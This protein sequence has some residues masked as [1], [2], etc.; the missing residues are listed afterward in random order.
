MALKEDST[1][2]AWGKNEYGQTTG[3]PGLRA[4]TA[5]AAGG[6]HSLALSKNG[7][8]VAWGDNSYG[9]TAVPDGLR[10]VVAIAGGG[11]HSLALVADAP[12]LARRYRGFMPMV[13]R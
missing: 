7:T 9:Q 6:W 10:G 4:V 5:I 12:Q 11:R 2:V 1:V 13:G 3:P 8:V